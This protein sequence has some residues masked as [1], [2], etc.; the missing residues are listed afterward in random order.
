M[1][2][3]WRKKQEEIEATEDFSHHSIPM[4]RIKKAIV[5]KNGKM[6]MTH[7]TPSFITKACEI[8]VQE[9]LFHAWM[10]ANSHHRRIIVESDIVEAITSLESYPFLNNILHS[11]EEQD[12]STPSEP[13]KN[14]NHRLASTSHQLPSDQYHMPQSIPQSLGYSPSFHISPFPT[15]HGCRMPLSLPCIPQEACPL[16]PTTITSAPIMDRDLGFSRN[17][18][19]NNIIV[20]LDATNPSQLLPIAE[21]VT[22]NSYSMSTIPSTSCYFVS[23]SN[24]TAHDGSSVLQFSIPSVDTNNSSPV[25]TGVI[26]LNHSKPKVAHAGNVIYARCIRTDAIDPEVTIDFDDDQHQH[27]RIDPEVLPTTNV[28][29]ANKDINWDVVD[30]AD[31]K[32]LI[33]FWKDVMMNEDPTPSIATTYIIDRAFFP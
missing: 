33:K 15:T 11:D 3:F 9:L 2:E 10:Y 28:T 19:D 24:P 21:L 14:H 16:T 31:D 32:L 8:F 22:T 6:M 17:N 13:T 5:A 30:M 20:G 18:I 26:E 29:G 1:K 12:N 4:S 7:D 25:V 27:G 23:D